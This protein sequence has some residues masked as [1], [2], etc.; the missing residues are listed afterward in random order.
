MF[1][2]RRGDW[3]GLPGDRPTPLPSPSPSPPPY[4]PP[5][6]YIRPLSNIISEYTDDNLDEEDQ[7]KYPFKRLLKGS[8]DMLIQVINRMG[9]SYSNGIKIY[10]RN[11]SNPEL[12]DFTI[13]LNVQNSGNQYDL[14]INFDFEDQSIEIGNMDLKIFTR[15]D[16]EEDYYGEDWQQNL[17]E[18]IL[19]GLLFSC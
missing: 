6:F 8:M 9:A 17:Q 16:S 19:L 14:G 1:L 3:I 7:K 5:T 12:F 2:R 18:T 13:S 4:P 10:E 15:S 11:N